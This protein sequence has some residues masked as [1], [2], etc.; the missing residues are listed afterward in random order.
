MTLLL[1]SELVG[2][3][4]GPDHRCQ[5]CL[6]TTVDMSQTVLAAVET[7]AFGV[8]P[9]ATLW[10]STSMSMSLAPAIRA[11]MPHPDAAVGVVPKPESA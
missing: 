9:A 7:V 10:S 3:R 6:N 1:G 8:P 11:R 2:P 4:T 5:A